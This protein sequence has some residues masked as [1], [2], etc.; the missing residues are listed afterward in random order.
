MFSSRMT[1]VTPDTHQARLAT[2]GKDADSNSNSDGWRQ[3]TAGPRPSANWSTIVQARSD[4]STA[5]DVHGGNMT[6]GRDSTG[7][8]PTSTTGATSQVPQVGSPAAPK[9]TLRIFPISVGASSRNPY[10]DIQRASA[11]WAQCNVKVVG[12]IGMCI[13]GAALDLQEPKGVLNE[14]SNPSSP[15]TEEQALLAKKATSAGAVPAYYVPRMSAGS[16]G[17]SFWPAV[18]PTSAVVISDSAASDSLAHELGHVLLNDGGHHS[19]P[20]NLMASGGIRNVGVD[21]LDAG[22]CGKL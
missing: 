22:Q 16:R 11:V 18:S 17:E 6:S 1:D 13:D 8:V 4:Q 5:K 15:T 2:P 21:K 10:P 7:T 12:E 19:D 9:R 3:T 20:D 14:Y